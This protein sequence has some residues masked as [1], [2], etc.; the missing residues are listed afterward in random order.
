MQQPRGYICAL[1]QLQSLEWASVGHVVLDQ[2]SLSLFAL[3]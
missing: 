3:A 2:I 1:L